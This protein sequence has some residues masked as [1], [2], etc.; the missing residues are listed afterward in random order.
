[1]A[2]GVLRGIA[3]GIEQDLGPALAI[4]LTRD[5]GPASARV[6]A[7]NLLPAVGEGLGSEQMQSGFSSLARQIAAQLVHGT[8]EA[9]ETERADDE[10]EGKEGAMAV[11]GESVAKGYTIALFFVFA[12]VTALTVL[13]MLLFRSR[14]RYR[15]LMDESK[16]HEDFTMTHAESATSTP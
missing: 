4:T 8:D 11:F 6:M 7:E 14:R 15:R 12:L 9:L 3:R 10:A 13:G 16:H 5:L 1:V 2:H